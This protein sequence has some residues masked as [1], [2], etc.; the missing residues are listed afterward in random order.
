MEWEEKNTHIKRC[1]LKKIKKEPKKPKS[2]WQ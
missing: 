1:Y 2:L